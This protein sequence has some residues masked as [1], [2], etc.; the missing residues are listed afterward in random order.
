MTNHSPRKANHGIQ[1]S[2]PRATIAPR[3][4]STTPAI[5]A[6]DTASPSP[7]PSS[8]T[9]AS[10][11]KHILSDVPGASKLA[12]ELRKRAGTATETYVAYGSTEK[13]Y[14]ECAR[15]AAL[16]VPQAQEKDAE[17]PK[18]EAGEDLGVGKGWWFEELGLVPTFNTWAQ[19]TMLHMHL[20]TVRFRAFPPNHAP[21]WHQHLLDH[22]FYDAENRMTVDYN[23]YASGVRTKYL[24][25]LFIQWRG[26]LAAYDEGFVKGDAVLA[27]AIWRNVFK[28]DEDVDLARLAQVVSYWRRVAS[29]LEKL[30]DEAVAGGD[31]TFGDPAREIGVVAIRSKFMDE[32]FRTQEIRPAE[33]EEGEK[34]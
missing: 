19:V 12:R 27:T 1:R 8:A 24:K 29:G 9:S 21:A 30:E 11:S 26:A 4:F 3:A 23:I 10:K 25:D 6:A 7:Q 15:Q 22:F 18:T 34:K 14:R 28:A 5:L 20:L 16:S 32:P 2:T 17:V 13:L 31:F 33:G